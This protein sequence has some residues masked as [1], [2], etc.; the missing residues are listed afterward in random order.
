VAKERATYFAEAP[1][2]VSMTPHPENTLI[3]PGRVQLRQRIQ[4]WVRQKIGRVL[5]A[6]HAP[7]KIKEF[8][9]VDPITNE[10]VYLS[11][12]ARYSVLH[13]GSKRFFFDRLTGRFDGTGTLFQERIVDRLQFLD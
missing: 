13:V 8:E 6:L 1:S 11:T 2:K 3:V 7:A 4:D 5:E 10:I 12:G 9:C